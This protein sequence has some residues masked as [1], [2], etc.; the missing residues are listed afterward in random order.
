MLLFVT[1]LFPLPDQNDKT[2]DERLNHYKP[3]ARSGIPLHV[4]TASSCVETIQNMSPIESVSVV[5]LDWTR[6]C[7]ISQFLHQYP[8]LDL[9]AGNPKKDTRSFLTLMNCKT[10]LVAKAA[11]SYPHATHLAWIDLNV[12]HVVRDV[13]LA[14]QRLLRLTRKP[15]SLPRLCIPSIWPKNECDDL[16]TRVCWRFAGGFFIGDRASVLEFHAQS[17]NALQRFVAKYKRLVW[18]VNIWAFI[19]RCGKKLDLYE[20]VC[21]HDESLFDIQTLD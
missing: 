14:T 11:Q 3:L 8:D 7:G 19:E 12:F 13:E 2:L 21:N 20:M 9:P 10:E 5:A 17:F 4:F 18:E 16:L 6:E 15:C 1:C